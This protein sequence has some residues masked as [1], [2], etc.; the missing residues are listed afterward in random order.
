ME[1]KQKQ[2]QFKEAHKTVERIRNSG[3]KPNEMKQEFNNLEEKKERLNEKLSRIKKK[4]ERVPNLKE[5][6]VVAEVIRREEEE[7][8]SLSERY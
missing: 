6:L 3:F 2:Q 8:N 5:L 7:Q 4:L 1:Y